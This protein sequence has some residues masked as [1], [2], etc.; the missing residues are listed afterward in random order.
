MTEAWKTRLP[1]GQKM[2]LLALADNANDMG[3]CYP[4]IA[5]LAAKCSMSERA[6]QGHLRGLEEAGIVERDMRT[7]RSTL[8]T[9][10]PRKFCTSAESAP[11]QNLH[12][13]PAEIAKTPAE[14]APSP[15]E[16]API[17][18]TQPSEP[19]RTTKRDEPFVLPDW[20][21]QD[22][23][24]A[25][26]EVRKKAKAASTDYAH[27]LIVNQLE[28]FRADGLNPVE[29]IN[30]SIRSGW[31]DVYRPKAGQAQGKRPGYVHDIRQMDYTKGVGDD[32]RF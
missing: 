6:V 2:V 12:H 10:N 13:T 16:S 1:T 8:Y 31:K 4:S 15:A 29:I 27:R 21:P 17:T 19:K 3:E 23:W 14:S 7:G 9:I 24:D 32:G 18:T 26:M 20:I 11:Q 5:T 25:F 22:T 30:N 28:K